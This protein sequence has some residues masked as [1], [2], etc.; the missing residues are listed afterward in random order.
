MARGR[1]PLVTRIPRSA[2]H[3]LRQVGRR[4]PV[5]PMSGFDG[6]E[7]VPDGDGRWRVVET[8]RPASEAGIATVTVDEHHGF[9]LTA[10]APARPAGPYGTLADAVDAVAMWRLARFRGDRP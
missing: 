9:L 8:G 1:P 7:A 2:A 3:L 5:R 6:L 10:E 4:R